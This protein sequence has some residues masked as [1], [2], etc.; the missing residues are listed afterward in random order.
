MLLTAFY[1]KQGQNLYM[2]KAKE[3]VD[4][5]VNAASEN[6]FMPRGEKV[7]SIDA[8]P[9]EETGETPQAD[10]ADLFMTPE[11]DSQWVCMTTY[12]G[13]PSN[14]NE[15]RNITSIGGSLQTTVRG[16]L[17]KQYTA[18][19]FS[20]KKPIMLQQDEMVLVRSTIWFKSPLKDLADDRQIRSMLP[21]SV[22]ESDA[23]LS[24]ISRII[25]KM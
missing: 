5:L 17:E 13:N 4:E 20:M 14:S 19:D 15:I 9:G 7:R 21:P 8:P 24:E 2:N 25:R 10:E 23:C 1:A 22:R 11:G 16:D 3:M 6:F 12:T 18:K